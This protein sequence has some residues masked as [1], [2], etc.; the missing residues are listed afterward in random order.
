MEV[1]VTTV[2]GLVLDSP[3][4]D[5]ELERAV[6]AERGAAL[7]RWSGDPE[8]LGQADFVLHVKT[9]V[10]RELLGHLRRGA[11]VARYG[12]GLDTVDRP[13]AAARDIA[14]VGVR[15]YATAEV[16]QHAVAL[17]LAVA[18]GL[19]LPAPADPASAWN[20]VSERPF[21]LAGPVG[22]VGLGT[23]GCATAVLF[24]RFGLEVMA[25]ARR[26]SAA[27]GLVGVRLVSLDRLLAECELV[28]LHVALTQETHHLL[29]ARRLAQMR[30]EAILVNTARAGLVDGPSLLAA[31]RAGRLRGAGLD[32][33]EGPA[34]AELWRALDRESFNVVRTPHVGWYSRRSLERLRRRAVEEAITAVGDPKDHL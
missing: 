18:R 4:D 31:L 13:A 15:D 20:D 7:E 3:I 17:A 6:A 22:I 5:L 28:S 33:F 27:D 29:D 2:R 21:G 24:T 16:A 9:H 26:R 10:D 32:A 25:S 30:R 1:G 34:G 8:A 14:V 19:G 23:I 12:T 11:V